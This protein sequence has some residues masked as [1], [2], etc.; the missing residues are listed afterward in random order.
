MTKLEFVEVNP[1]TKPTAS[2]IWLHGLGADGHDFV[3]IVP[4][5]NLPKDLA[6]R[7]VFPHAPVRPVTINAGYEMRA[8]YDIKGLDT[9]SRQDEM[10]IRESTQAIHEL[11]ENEKQLG[12]PAERI[13]LG[14]FSQGGA[15]ALYC[16][17]R[18][19]Q[20]LAGIM[21]LSTY[22]PLS[23]TL[24]QEINEANRDTSIFMV[25]GNDDPVL[26]LQWA[27]GSRDIL[28]ELGYPVEFKTYPMPHSVCAEEI[29]D[30]A[31][32][33]KKVLETQYA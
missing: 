19:P 22:L 29:K 23:A 20:R 16:G 11:I 17:L 12:I 30:I 28:L 5:L 1:S 15:I 33:I 18:Y 26:P 7:F 27:L 31:N 14:G 25:H 10:G 24:P 8:W 3:N 9:A 21:A 6:L 13:I 2:I 4:E 32:W